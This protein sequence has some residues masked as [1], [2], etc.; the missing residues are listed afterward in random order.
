MVTYGFLLG[1]FLGWIPALI[2]ALVVAV[3]T[4]FLW[5]LP[6]LAFLY[7]IYRAFGFHRGLLNIA[8]FVAIF[9]IAM[10]WWW[11]MVRHNHLP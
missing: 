7:V 1:F 5:P 6:A 9:A 3:A 11:H 2:L 8:A 4:I 10:V